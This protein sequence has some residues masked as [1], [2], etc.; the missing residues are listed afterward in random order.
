[1][2]QNMNNPEWITLKDLSA[3]KYIFL[4]IQLHNHSAEPQ[5]KQFKIF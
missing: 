5:R 2:E 3:C 4:P 1:M